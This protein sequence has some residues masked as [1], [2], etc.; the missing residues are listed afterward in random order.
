MAFKL[1]EKII[2]CFLLLDCLEVVAGLSTLFLKGLI[3]FFSIIEPVV[4]L[5]EACF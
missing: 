3:Q 1:P 4:L 5:E 2:W